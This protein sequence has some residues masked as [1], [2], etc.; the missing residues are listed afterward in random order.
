MR[1]ADAAVGM[2]G[3]GV[4]VES[5]GGGG[6]G[7]TLGPEPGWAVGLAGLSQREIFTDNLLVRVHFITETE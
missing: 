7:K 3:G 1:G 2:G 4:R 6:S 5:R